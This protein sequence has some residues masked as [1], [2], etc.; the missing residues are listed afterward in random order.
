MSNLDRLLNLFSF[1]SVSLGQQ[2]R[3]PLRKDHSGARVRPPHRPGAQRRRALF[4]RH[5]REKRNGPA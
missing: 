5:E 1:L 2:H 4:G 3:L